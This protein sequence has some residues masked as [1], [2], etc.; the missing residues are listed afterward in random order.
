MRTWYE[1]A[2]KEKDI[3]DSK[4]KVSDRNPK[5]DTPNHRINLFECLWDNVGCDNSAEKVESVEA[6][7]VNVVNIDRHE[8]GKTDISELKV[9]NLPEN[10]SFGET[11][12]D[13]RAEFCES[14]IEIERNKRRK[15]I[16]VKNDVDEESLAGELL[17]N[18]VDLEIGC[19]NYVG[20]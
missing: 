11:S 13:S 10:E 5:P 7:T 16:N 4:N 1:S 8:E 17:E 9:K 14:V 20:E 12:S 18:Y 2:E 15:E 6:K 19:T 3:G